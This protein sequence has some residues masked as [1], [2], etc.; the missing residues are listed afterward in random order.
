MLWG[1]ATEL[2]G[3]VQIHPEKALA[4]LINQ[5]NTSVAL[6]DVK[7]LGSFAAYAQGAL[8]AR[9]DQFDDGTPAIEYDRLH[10]SDRTKSGFVGVY[11]NGQGFRAHA[12][13][14]HGQKTI[15]TFPTAAEAAWRRYLY[16]KKHHLPY[17]HFEAM[18]GK[19]RKDPRYKDLPERAI[20]KFAAFE[21]GQ[22]NESHESIPDE[23]QRWYKHD[24]SDDHDFLEDN[25]RPVDPKRE[26]GKERETREIEARISATPA[27]QAQKAEEARLRKIAD[28]YD[29]TQVM[30]ERTEGEAKAGKATA[31]TVSSPPTRH[32]RR[33]VEENRQQQTPEY[34]QLAL[35]EA[36]RF[37]IDLPRQAEPK[38]SIVFVDSIDYAAIGAAPANAQ[39]RNEERHQQRK[40]KEH[41]CRGC[42]KAG[43]N[44][45]RCPD[46]I[47]G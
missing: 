23:Y 16:Y 26:T 44:L 45:R 21:L 18:L 36:G 20:Y 1:V 33:I 43:H 32:E 30:A 11:Q 28:D 2:A 24:P 14:G 13:S 9:V 6:G 46:R 3:T 8:N 35:K 4:L 38:P 42:G 5:I 47:L 25:K 15:G 37:A 34:A 27:G 19:C 22:L 17:G 7:F 40:H 41:A 10:E 31:P 12:E 29:R 39:E